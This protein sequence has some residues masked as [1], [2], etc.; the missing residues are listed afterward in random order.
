MIKPYEPKLTRKR[1]TLRNITILKNV[2]YVVVLTLL[3]IFLLC[4]IWF[5]NA[6]NNG[7]CFTVIASN[8]MTP[9]YQVMDTI[10]YSPKQG[11][12]PYKPGDNIVF[13]KYDE[14]GNMEQVFHKLIRISDKFD[15]FYT[16]GIANNSEDDGFRHISDILGSEDYHIK[17]KIVSLL[18]L[19][20]NR[21]NAHVAVFVISCLIVAMG[22]FIVFK[23]LLKP[24]SRSEDAYVDSKSMERFESLLRAYN[25]ASSE[26]E[27]IKILK[28]ILSIDTWLK[29]V[30]SGFD[31]ASVGNGNDSTSD[32]NSQ[33]KEK[34]SKL[35]ERPKG[36]LSD[37]ERA[38]KEKRLAELLAKV[39]AANSCK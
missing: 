19:A 7:K 36:L 29:N 28:E 14:Q 22:V 11:D 3:L 37:E 6:R 30:S 25:S 34:S 23:I 33:K 12:M 15:R 2:G 26:K 10:V 13:I 9:T 38:A 35:P 20:M 27:S 32:K 5:I 17:S 4:G 1:H 21:I 31:V 18:I 8:S 16:K 24:F 39:N